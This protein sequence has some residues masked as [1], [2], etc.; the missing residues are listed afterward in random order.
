MYDKTT[1]K[2]NRAEQNSVKE[3]SGTRRDVQEVLTFII[4][5]LG[6]L[7]YFQMPYIG[8]YITTQISDNNIYQPVYLPKLS[9]VDSLTDLFTFFAVVF[10]IYIGLMIGAENQ[11]AKSESI[12]D[13]I[14]N[15]KNGDS[16]IKY[17]DI[18]AI[19]KEITKYEFYP[20]LLYALGIFS[21]LI[22][23]WYLGTKFK[24]EPNKED[25][26]WGILTEAPIALT[27][28]FII[29]ALVKRLSGLQVSTSKFAAYRNQ[30]IL[31][32]RLKWLNLFGNSE[33]L[34]IDRVTL[35]DI[36]EKLRCYN[37]QRSR[38]MKQW[39]K[40]GSSFLYS[41]IVPLIILSI[42]IFIYLSFSLIRGGHTTIGDFSLSFIYLFMILIF[43]VFPFFVFGAFCAVV[44]KTRRYGAVPLKG[45]IIFS[46]SSVLL[47]VAAFFLGVL[48]GIY[49]SHG[50]G[51]SVISGLVFLGI[52]AL[53]S[54]WVHRYFGNF[55]SYFIM[56][57]NNSKREIWI[58]LLFKRISGIK[59]CGFKMN[60]KLY[61]LSDLWHKNAEVEPGLS[62]LGDNHEAEHQR[63][64]TKDRGRYPHWVGAL[65]LWYLGEAPKIN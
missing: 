26:T 59:R 41:F 11:I 37:R 45:G 42:W 16:S 57:P 61:G 22:V 64:D 7:L 4:V 38:F 48:L 54:W 51:Y 28:L 9:G 55:C 43:V 25:W 17:S 1:L 19:Q 60:C 8:D 6:F 18:V 36:Q 52:G 15:K 47:L 14:I 3:S 65:V 62:D 30:F 63:I 13:G 33:S 58:T 24:F 12:I 40:T 27:F 32:A 23:W 53:G 35:G 20:K 2:R 46:F 39:K 31:Y 29:Y 56:R 44:Y 50:W 10:A 34:D 21:Q 49:R 5:Q